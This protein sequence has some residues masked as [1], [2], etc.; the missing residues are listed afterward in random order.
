VSNDVL[1]PAVLDM[2]VNSAEWVTAIQESIV[3]L[4]EL[5]VEIDST[6][7]E[8]G[9]FG[10]VMT[11]SAA[12]AGAA[13]DTAAESATGTGRRTGCVTGCGGGLSRR[14]GGGAR[15]RCRVR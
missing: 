15:P 8:L 1:P 4:T 12:T 10:E 7:T 11:E 6:I 14:T 13:M 3:P 9:A 5:Q 2:I